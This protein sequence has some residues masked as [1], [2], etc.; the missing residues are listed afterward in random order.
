MFGLPW[1][2]TFWVFGAPIFW[3]L[4]TLIFLFRTRSWPKDSN[5]EDLH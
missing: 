4:Y 3:I 5:N 1:E 2:T